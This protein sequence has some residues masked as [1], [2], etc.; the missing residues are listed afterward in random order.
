M[1]P[2]R[3]VSGGQNRIT[4]LADGMIKGGQRHEYEIPV[5]PSMVDRSQICFA[6]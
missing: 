3:V 6:L 1:D 5:P 2:T 4:L